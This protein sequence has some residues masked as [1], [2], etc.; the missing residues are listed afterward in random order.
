MK[1]L[2]ALIFMVVLSS[3]SVLAGEHA[4]KFSDVDADGDGKV[5]IEEA[6]VSGIDEAKATTA[7]GD[8]GALD[9]S[10]FS[11]LEMEK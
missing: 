1:K 6:K 11:A 2:F 9:E 4:K 7:A 10:E 3:G 5:T 8:D